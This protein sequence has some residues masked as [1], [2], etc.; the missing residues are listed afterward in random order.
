M[1]SLDFSPATIELSEN[2]IFSAYGSFIQGA[3]A[4]FARDPSYLVDMAEHA[5]LIEYKRLLWRARTEASA[6]LK[7]QLKEKPTPDDVRSLAAELLKQWGVSAP[8]KFS[9]GSR[10][11]RS[12]A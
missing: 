3:V 5:T 6:Q 12:E 4:A 11:R 8:G 7:A 2:E 9:R 10:R 1:T